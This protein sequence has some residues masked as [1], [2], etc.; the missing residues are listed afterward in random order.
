M[1]GLPPLQP[2][3]SQPERSECGPAVG[4]GVKLSFP[5]DRTPHSLERRWGPFDPSLG[6]FDRPPRPL[7]RPPDPLERSG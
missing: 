6:P 7:E 4:G 3:Q 2:R 5:F 1:Q